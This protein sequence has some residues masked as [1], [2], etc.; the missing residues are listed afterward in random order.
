M[1]R[2]LL[3]FK[4]RC[5]INRYNKLC[6]NDRLPACG[7]QPVLTPFCNVCTLEFVQCIFVNFSATLLVVY[8]LDILS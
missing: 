6:R 1:R 2:F 5:L 7:N 8:V 4:M 3:L